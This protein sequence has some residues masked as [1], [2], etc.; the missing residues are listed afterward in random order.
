MLELVQKDNFNEAVTED[1]YNQYFLNAEGAKN[2]TTA[3]VAQLASDQTAKS[4]EW[5]NTTL[6]GL[7]VAA[8]NKGEF[9]IQ[10]TFPTDLN[11]NEIVS[12]LTE[13][14]YSCTNMQNGST[15]IQWK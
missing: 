15:L 13:A 9:Q 8:I 11:K 4:I 3:I 5:I 6:E 2:Q 10:I 12:A 7:I 14:G 1:K